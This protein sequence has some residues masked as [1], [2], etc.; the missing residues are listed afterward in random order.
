VSIRK[1]ESDSF[2]RTVSVLDRQ[3]KLLFLVRVRARVRVRV[4]Y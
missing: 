1:D 2:L 3:A 4:N